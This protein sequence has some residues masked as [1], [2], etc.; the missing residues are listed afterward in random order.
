MAFTMTPTWLHSRACP[1]YKLSCIFPCQE[2]KFLFKINQIQELP[3][4]TV[5]YLILNRKSRTH[6]AEVDTRVLFLLLFEYSRVAKII[7]S[8]ASRGE[9]DKAAC[10]IRWLG[11]RLDQW[12]HSNTPPPSYWSTALW[13]LYG[14]NS[15]VHL[16]TH[17]GN[18]IAHSITP[19][20]VSLIIF[21]VVICLLLNLRHTSLISS[22]PL[23]VVFAERK[24]EGV[25]LISGMNQ[26]R[27]TVYCCFEIICCR[28]D[29]F[30]TLH[31]V[32]AINGFPKDEQNGLNQF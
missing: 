22:E 15:H 7:S 17:L 10:D 27:I 24:C 12:E 16:S 8:K 20:P 5:Q 19:T 1:E 25:G 9:S 29:L 23:A 2:G 28:D 3:I 21:D 30:Q 14:P 13:L 4:G 32:L 6:Y 26:W 18:E 11:I 31:T